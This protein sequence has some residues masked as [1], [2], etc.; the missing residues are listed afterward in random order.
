M[1]KIQTSN[2]QVK[3]YFMSKFTESHEFKV[4]QSRGNNFLKMSKDYH[5]IPLPLLIEILG[6]YNYNKVPINKNISQILSL[7]YRPASH[8]YANLRQNFS[9]PPK[10][11]LS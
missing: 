8:K 2:Y 10:V 7:E 4:F 6:K 11:F 5:F 9:H 3:V 1:N